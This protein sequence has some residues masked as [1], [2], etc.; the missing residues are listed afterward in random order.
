MLG[1]AELERK[2]RQLQT[3]AKAIGLIITEMEVPPEV[4]RELESVDSKRLVK[5]RPIFQSPKNYHM[6]FPEGALGFFDGIIFK[7][8]R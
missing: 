3:D 8:K 2:I 6:K 4:V 7:A 1:K 5:H